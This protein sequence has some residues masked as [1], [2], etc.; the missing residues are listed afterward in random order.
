[1]HEVYMYSTLLAHGLTV[2][3]LNG[4]TRDNGPWWKSRILQALSFLMANKMTCTWTVCYI[5]LFIQYHHKHA[6]IQSNDRPHN[7]QGSIPLGGN[8]HKS[9][10]TSRVFIWTYPWCG[11]TFSAEHNLFKYGIRSTIFHSRCIPC[12]FPHTLPQVWYPNCCIWRYK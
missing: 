5:D 3:N 6:N 9:I 8:K 12:P 7:M 11:L 1:M 10:I 2:C 4:S